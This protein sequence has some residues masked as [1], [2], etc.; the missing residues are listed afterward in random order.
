MPSDFSNEHL[1]AWGRMM[2]TS[3]RSFDYVRICKT[4]FRCVLTRSGLAQ[5]LPGISHRK[6]CNYGIPLRKFPGTIAQ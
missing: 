1:T 4:R 5:E 6:L 2:L 3:Q